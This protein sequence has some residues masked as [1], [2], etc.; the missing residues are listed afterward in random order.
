MY[1]LI[2]ISEEIT[3]ETDEGFEIGTNSEVVATF[4]KMEDAE[5]YAEASKLSS[6]RDWSCWR[7]V[8]RQFRK[9]SLLR[10]CLRYEI[11]VAVPDIPPPHNPKL[12][13]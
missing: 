10:G 8:N 1:N 6:Y 9:K 2:G 7:D 4:D 12:E 11:E 5:A 13:L 3:N